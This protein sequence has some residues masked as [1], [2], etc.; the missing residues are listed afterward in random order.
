MTEKRNPGNYSGDVSENYSDDIS[1]NYS[2]EERIYLRIHSRFVKAR[3]VRI[4]TLNLI[5]H[6]I[7]QIFRPIL[8]EGREKEKK[9]NRR[10]ANEHVAITIVLKKRKS[11]FFKISYH[12]EIRSPNSDGEF[13]SVS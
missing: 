10:R 13:V 2:D 1:E 4:N 11:E 3:H 9:E 6:N 12:T 8:A 7:N 5:E